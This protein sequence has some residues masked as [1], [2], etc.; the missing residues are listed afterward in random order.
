V[1]RVTEEHRKNKG[2]VGPPKAR[3]QPKDRPPKTPDKHPRARRLLKRGAVVVSALVLLFSAVATVLV[4]RYNGNITRLPVLDTGITGGKHLPAAPSHAQNFLL[5][6]SDS[7]AGDNAGP[8]TGTA[9]EASGQRADTVILAHLFGS[10]DKAFMVSFPRDSWVEI[11]A[12]RD[13]KSHRQHAA[14]HAKLNSAIAEGG[15]ALL[16]ATIEQ[17]SGIRVDHYVQVD[18][19]GFRSMVNKLGGVDVCLSKPAHDTYSGLFLSAGR[20]HINGQVALAFVRQ[21]HGLPQ[22][23][24]DRIKRQQQ[25][26]GSMVNKVLSAGTLLNPL[27]LNGFLDVATSS[28]KVDET[29]SFTDLKN[30]ALRARRF[31][32]AGVLFATL[33]VAKING[34]VSGQSVVLLDRTADDAMFEALRQ[35]KVPGS[36]PA[37]KPSATPAVQPA[38][39]QVR[40]DN[41][42]GIN[43]LGRRVFA[44]LKAKGFATVGTPQTRGSG[45]TGSVVHYGPGKEA[46]AK[47]VAAAIP[48]ATVHADSSLTD[49]LQVVV[50]SSYTQTPKPASP[51]PVQSIPVRTAQQDPCA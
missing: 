6:G 25:M 12:W 32:S 42:S 33:P 9:A 29:M 17:L 39:V 27:R 11:P 37:P 35:D 26:L 22:G 28:L 34:Y 40:V 24:I 15:P 14:H 36:A 30:L 4:S 46:A 1:P 49:V 23:D 16:V 48:G 20:H 18:F 31:Q 5:V 2:P 8:N 50:G 45:A 38:S 21:R 10:S 7:R 3:K 41:G 51:K 19:Y 44:D 43:G 47:A 13:P